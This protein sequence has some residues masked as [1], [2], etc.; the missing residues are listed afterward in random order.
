MEDN[1]INIGEGTKYLRAKQ[2]MQIFSI[3][4][5]TVDN[6]AKSGIITR[7]KIGGGIFYE[8]AEIK[9]LMKGGIAGLV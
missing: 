4:R 9:Q 2:I 3:A 8:Y 1:I 7:H 6:W 5:S